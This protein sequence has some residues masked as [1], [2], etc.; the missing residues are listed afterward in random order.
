M[1]QVH[2]SLKM[3]SYLTCTKLEKLMRVLNLMVVFLSVAD[4]AELSVKAQTVI[5]L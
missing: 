1:E 5:L 3:K 2:Q 4:I